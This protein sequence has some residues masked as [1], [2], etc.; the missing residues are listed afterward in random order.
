[1]LQQ[2]GE[3]RTGGRAIWS[4]DHL[5][6]PLHG[7]AEEG[8]EVH[9]EDGPEDRDVENLEKGTAEGDDCGLGG[10]VPELELRQPPDERTELLAL[11]RR[12]PGGPVWRTTLV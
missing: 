12:Q 11:V 8:D 6:L 3:E 4:R 10:R 5:Y 1:M 9:D 2:E 7:D